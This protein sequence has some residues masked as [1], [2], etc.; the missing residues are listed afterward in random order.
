MLQLKKLTIKGLRSLKGLDLPLQKFDILIGRNNAGKSNTL[1]AIKLLLEATG[2]DVSLEDFYEGDAGNANEIELVGEFIIPPEYL[3]LCE[4]RHRT[5]IQECIEDNKL[6]TRRVISKT[7]DDKIEVGKLQLWQPDKNE[8]GLPTGIENALKQFLPEVIFIE[9]FKDPTQEAQGKSTAT[10]GKI[11]KQI[12]GQVSSQI[13]EDVDGAIKIAARRFNTFI[14]NNGDLIDERP[15]EL[16][17]V[18]NRIRKHVQEIFAGSDARLKFNLPKVDDLIATATVE[19]KDWGPW[20]LPDGK[21]QGFQR[22]LYV[23][24]LQSL[25]EE[26]RDE[27]NE[28]NR[29]FILLYEEPEAFLHPALQ[30]EIG[31]ILETISNTNQV[32][33]ATH[34]PVLVTSSRLDNVIILKQQIPPLPHSTQLFIPDPTLAELDEDRQLVSLLKLNNT[35]EFLFSDYI[36]VVEGVSDRA[37]VE[38][39]LSKIREGREI[40]F[41]AI[42]VIEAGSKDVVPVWIKHLQKMGF[43]TKGM[44]DLDFVWNGANNVLKNY[45]LLGKF[46]TQFWERMEREGLC[47]TNDE[48][49]HIINKKS[50]A[51]RIITSDNEFLPVVEKIRQ[52]LISKDI[53]AISKG[54]IESYFGL[55]SSSKNQYIPTSRKVRNGEIPIPDEIKEIIRWLTN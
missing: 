44:V 54:E 12:V 32:V 25:A 28:V 11:L 14:E 1:L 48:G 20:T 19:L 42:A 23:A 39:C 35:A 38:S 7:A 52:D 30:R 10:L 5:K 49:K 55:S 29:P 22:V 2:R 31:N 36:L 17:R 18:E 8:Y 41:Q 40:K 21:G 46:G 16:R 33:I 9:A 50:E 37:L 34:S 26:L 13:N 53:W 27:A 47:E 43:P 3:I 15:E 24:L 51:F 45:E 4:E 6:I